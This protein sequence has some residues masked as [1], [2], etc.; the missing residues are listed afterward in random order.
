MLEKSI[1]AYIL[2][3]FTHPG[4]CAC[5]FAQLFQ[6]CWGHA[7]AGFKVLSVISIPQCTAGPNIV[8]DLLRL[9]ARSFTHV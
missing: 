7:R 6:H 4:G 2:R 1:K 3:P 9:F 5:I 8:G